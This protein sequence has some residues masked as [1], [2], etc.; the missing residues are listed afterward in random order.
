[1]KA[2]W[3]GAIGF[4]LVNIPVKMYSA[5][6]SSNLELHMLDKKDLA[7]IRYKRVNEDSGAE[8]KYEN[9]VKGYN[10]D[11]KY[12]VLDE[13][14]YAAASP[15]KSK[16]FSIDEFVM[17]DEI[18]SVYFEVPYF[19]EPQKN[20]ESAYYLLLKALKE[21][22]RAGVGTFVMRDKEV[23]GMI[24]PYQDDILIVNRLRFAQE[25]RDYKQLKLPPKKEPKAGELKMAISLIEQTS[26]TFNPAAFHDTYAEDLMKIIKR[27]AKGTH[28]KKVEDEPKESGKVVDL[29]AQLKASLEHSKKNKKV[30]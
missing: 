12:I 30:S 4:G 11:G 15:E 21:S 6:E 14:D 19:L 29:M 24:R 9:I 20:A 17:E 23:L 3:N 8:V 2:I 27:K 25:I 22:K 28:I 13:E 26:E 7:H 5:V 16:I 1:M 10:L 18:D